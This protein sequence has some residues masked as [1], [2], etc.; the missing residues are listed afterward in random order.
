MYHGQ[1]LQWLAVQQT[2][3]DRLYHTLPIHRYAKVSL[4]GI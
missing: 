3:L 1:Y 4:L 2:L